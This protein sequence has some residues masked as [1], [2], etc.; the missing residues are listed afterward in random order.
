MSERNKSQQGQAL[1]EYI[2]VVTLIALGSIVAYSV[3]GHSVVSQSAQMSVQI[4][5]GEARS[6]RADVVGPG[7]SGKHCCGVR[8]NPPALA[9][10]PMGGLGKRG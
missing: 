4:S 9:D 2:I 3:L 5:G 10:E 1:V 8:G 7:G 6:A